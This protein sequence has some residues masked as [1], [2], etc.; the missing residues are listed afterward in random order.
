MTTFEYLAVL[1]SVIVGLAMTHILSGVARLLVQRTR[2][3]NDWIHLV[4]T[5]WAFA[6]LAYFW[7]FSFWFGTVQEWTPVLFSFLVLHSVILFIICSVLMPTDLPEDKD[8]TRYF[9]SQKRLFFGLLIASQ[10]VLWIDGVLKEHPFPGPMRVLWLFVLMAPGL[11]T[12]NR[13]YHGF[14]AIWWLCGVLYSLFALGGGY[15]AA[16]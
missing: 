12:E 8:F 9:F 6:Y 15:A 10:V 3:K 16:G 5:I 7:W 1:I 11:F 14:V 13:K 4:W 2:Y